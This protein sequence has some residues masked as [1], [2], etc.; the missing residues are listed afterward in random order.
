[1][2]RK[3]VCI[4]LP[5]IFGPVQLFRSAVT[6]HHGRRS[7]RTLTEHGEVPKRSEALLVIHMES[8]V[9]H[10]CLALA[11]CTA[12]L[13]AIIAGFCRWQTDEDSVKRESRN[14]RA[15]AKSFADAKN[16]DFKESREVERH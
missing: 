10:F 7:E 5:F 4:Y 11:T 9:V 8:T 13:F 16:Q 14:W 6:N 12:H 2:P 15:G 3:F 1:M